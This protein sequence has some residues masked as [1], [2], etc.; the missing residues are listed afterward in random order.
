M[1]YFATYL[2]IG[3]IISYGIFTG[4]KE[5]FQEFNYVYSRE[6]KNVKEISEDSDETS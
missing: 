1:I 2:L 4:L 5:L 3:S 6:D